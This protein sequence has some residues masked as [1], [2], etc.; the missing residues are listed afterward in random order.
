MEF[1]VVVW[2]VTLL[3]EVT[4]ANVETFGVVSVTFVVIIAEV[5]DTVDYYPFVELGIAVVPV[6]SMMLCMV[7]AVAR[8]GLDG[9][10]HN[11]ARDDCVAFAIQ[12]V[13]QLGEIGFVAEKLKAVDVESV[14]YR[15]GA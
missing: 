8:L 4:F 3:V 5:L 2:Q 14:Q 12:A 10:L 15:L 1:V 13:D 11:L 6:V 9:V 7:F